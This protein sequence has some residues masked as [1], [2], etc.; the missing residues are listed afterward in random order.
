MEVG[1]LAAAISLLLAKDMA[2]AM[3]SEVG[4]D[5]AGA[6][7]QA[8][9]RLQGRLQAEPATR[10]AV[11][12]LQ[13]APNDPQLQAVLAGLLAAQLEANQALRAEVRSLVAELDQAVFDAVSTAPTD[14]AAA[15]GGRRTMREALVTELQELERGVPDGLAGVPTGFPELDQLIGGLRAGTL[16]VVAGATAVGTST[17]GL[18]I[19]RNASIR[20]GV[21]T[22]F[23]SLD[24]T[25]AEV[26]N[27]L[28][29]AEGSI[30]SQRLRRGRLDERDWARITRMLGRMADAPLT[31]EASPTLTVREL[32]A[33]CRHVHEHTGL[34]LVVVDEVSAVQRPRPMD[35]SQR[36]REVV[37]S[38]KLLARELAVPVVAL[39]R[40]AV[41]WRAD[42]EPMLADLTEVERHTADLVML[43]HRPELDDPWSPR[44]GEADLWVAKHR[45]GPTGLI[46]VTFQGAYCRFAPMASRD[47]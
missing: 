7:K 28:L 25:A 40:V 11:E 26:A 1:A 12:R 47:L 35:G 27:R 6:A 10:A 24:L 42:P 18:D 21:P 23:V 15:G 22:V 32:T 39:S 20:A 13:A 14:A 45:A 46:T 17:L 16:V 29:C 44:R 43:V 38:L 33:T 19:A 2:S 34:G 4:K 8:L 31:I 41:G 36:D 3:A 5:I 9:G 37:R 30:D